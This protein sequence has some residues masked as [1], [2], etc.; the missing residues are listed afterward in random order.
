VEETYERAR[1]LCQGLEEA[2]HLFEAVWGL[3]NYYQARGVLDTAQALA[4]Q[5][6]TIAEHAEETRLAVWAHLQ[7]GATLFFRGDAAA[8]LEHLDVAITRHDP[9]GRWFLTGAPEPGVSA[10]AYAGWALWQLGEP[11]RALRTSEEAIALGRACEHPFTLALAL[12]FHATLRQ[13]RREPEACRATAAEVIA[14][15]DAQ[16]YPLWRGMGHI[17]HGWALTH[18]GHGDAGIE[19]M[20]EGVAGMATTGTEVGASSF[21]GQL[22]EASLAAGRPGEALSAVRAG[23]AIAAERGHGM[24]DADLHRLEG[25]VLEA[26]EDTG[27]EESERCYRLALERAGEQRK[28]IFELRA[29]LGLC[30]MLCRRGRDTAD[31]R[32]ALQAVYDRFSEGFD[33][34]D[35]A[36]ARAMLDEL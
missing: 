6:V 8:S 4:E 12:A 29:A 33:T 20:Q 23:I 36:E 31:A 17:L 19:E 16:E 30:R 14:L 10:R 2:P 15:A 34:P 13:I 18:G 32:R 28:P 1:V 11:E 35:L 21:F 5:L 26:A 3:A 27:D 25:D 9:E 24:V 22:A 7:L